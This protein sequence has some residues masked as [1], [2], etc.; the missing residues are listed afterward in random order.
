MTVI[1]KR[2]E[3]AI[4]QWGTIQ[5]FSSAMSEL[6]IRGSSLRMIQLYLAG[7]H[8]PSLEFVHTAAEILGVREPW[9]ALGEEPM[10]AAMIDEDL[11]AAV[12]SEWEWIIVGS[13]TIRAQLH[14]LLNRR[15]VAVKSRGGDVN[16]DRIRGWARDIKERVKGPWDDWTRGIGSTEADW[17]NYR[18]AMVHALMLALP[19]GYVSGKRAGG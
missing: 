19:E 10:R 8:K 9:L 14:A 15:I 12:E 2:L 6:G 11:T 4:K 17:Y 13:E 18:V 7:T 3:V 1:A 5:A 16:E